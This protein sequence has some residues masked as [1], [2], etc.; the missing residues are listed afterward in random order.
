VRQID[1][2]ALGHQAA[3]DRVGQPSFVFHDEHPHGPRLP[4]PAVS[5]EPLTGSAQPACG[6]MKISE[7][8]KE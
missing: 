6:K 5:A 2:E 7:C 1:R 3:A 8:T 4:G